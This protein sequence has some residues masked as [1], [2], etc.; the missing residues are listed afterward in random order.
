M[1]CAQDVCPRQLACS[2]TSIQLQPQTALRTSENLRFVKENQTLRGVFPMATSV[3]MPTYNALAVSDGSNISYVEAGASHL[4]P[5]LLLHGFPS[6]SNQFRNFI[7]LLSSS[8]HIIAPDL[9]GFGHTTTPA[10]YTFTFDNLAATISAFLVALNVAKYSIYIFDY[11]APVGLRLALQKPEA[12]SAIISQ[13]GNAYVEGFGRPFWDPIF[14]L[15]NS[16]N[17]AADRE[18]LRNNYLT[19]DGT[20]MQYTT[21]VPASDLSLI[22]PTAYTYDY[23]VNLVGTEKQNHQLDL[24]Y[25]Y[26]TNAPMYPTIHEYFRKSQ[27]PLLAI[28]GKGDPVFVPPGAEGFKKDLPN[29]IVKFVDSGH[30]ALETK[31]GE[32]AAEVLRFLKGVEH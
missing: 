29:A 21:G 5:L 18:F 3:S 15:Q 23:L 26:R 10:S 2:R 4:P 19:L 11:G 16:F 27:V 9:P 7:P 12:V 32:I 25:D 20:K 6:S 28:W 13:N 17:S 30:F 31:V 1:A 14:A 24:F 8:Y 22:D